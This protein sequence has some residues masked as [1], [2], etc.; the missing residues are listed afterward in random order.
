MN[1]GQSLGSQVADVFAVRARADRAGKA[2]GTPAIWDG[3]KNN[4]TSRGDQYWL[5]LELPS[6]PPML[7][8]FGKVIPFLFDTL[9]V[10]ALR[11]GPPNL[12]GSDAFKKEVAEVQSYSQ[13]VTRRAPADS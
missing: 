12:A 4:A 9:T 5:S 10:V 3:L 2:I 6:R 1:A 11:P 8:L 7:P 13:N